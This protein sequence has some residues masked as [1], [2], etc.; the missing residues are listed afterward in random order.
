MAPLENDKLKSIKT[1]SSDLKD[2][3]SSSASSVTNRTN[4]AQD[5]FNWT[6]HIEPLLNVMNTYCKENKEKEFC[7]ACDHLS[8]LLETHQM[9]SKSCDKRAIILKTIFKYLDTDSDKMKLKISK[10]I[11]NVSFYNFYKISCLLNSIF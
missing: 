9:L 1:N 6:N 2:R 10:I 5:D 8:N 4:A 11:L 7:D 3:E